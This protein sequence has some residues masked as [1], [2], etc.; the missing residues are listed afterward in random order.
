MESFPSALR[1]SPFATNYSLLALIFA[2]IIVSIAMPSCSKRGT[3]VITSKTSA[4]TPPENVTPENT[5]SF[6]QPDD[7]LGKAYSIR[8]ENL[9]SKLDPNGPWNRSH[10]I[11]K[12]LLTADGFKVLVIGVE[13]RNARDSFFN[14]RFDPKLTKPVEVKEG[15]LLKKDGHKTLFLGLTDL[16]DFVP[17]GVARTGGAEGINGTG[18]LATIRFETSDPL[19]RTSRLSRRYAPNDLIAYET[20]AGARLEW[21]HNLWGDTDNDFFCNSFDVSRIAQAYGTKKGDPN[22]NDSADT[23]RDGTVDSLDLMAIY[24]DFGIFFTIA[25]AYAG[26]GTLLSTIFPQIS[27]TGTEKPRLAID[28]GAPPVPTTATYYVTLNSPPNETPPSNIAPLQEWNSIN[29]EIENGRLFYLPGDEISLRITT[30]GDPGPVR[31]YKALVNFTA[32]VLS[33]SLGSSYLDTLGIFRP[34]FFF[35]NGFPGDGTLNL[36]TTALVKK[37][38]IVPTGKNTLVRNIRFLVDTTGAGD[39]QF[40]FTPAETY[41]EGP[42]NVGP[43]AF[44]KYGTLTVSLDAS[45]ILDVAIKASPT[46]GLL[47]FD[48]NFSSLVYGGTPPYSYFW[49]FDDGSFDSMA[50]PLH[51]YADGSITSFPHEYQVVLLVQDSASTQLQALDS[52]SVFAA[53]LKNRPPAIQSV[54]AMPGTVFLTQATSVD[55]VATDPDNDPLAY[56]WTSTLTGTF[57]NPTAQTTSYTPSELGTHTLIVTVS[58]GIFDD[59]GSTTVDVIQNMNPTAI[60]IAD[61]TS[62]VFPLTVNFDASQSFDTDGTIVLYEMDYEGDGTYDASGTNPTFQHTYP[63]W[64]TYYAMLRVTDD[65]GQ[66]S[67]YQLTILVTTP[68][69]G[70]FKRPEFETTQVYPQ[71]EPGE[72]VVGDFNEDNWDDIA[73][74]TTNYMFPMV[75]THQAQTTGAYTPNRMFSL[76]GPAT[77]IETR[78]LNGDN[79][80]D[81]I[82]LD[83][84]GS[85]ISILKGD[86]TGDFLTLTGITNLG[87]SWVWMNTGDYDGDTLIDIM[88]FSNPLAAGPGPQQLAVEMQFHKGNGDATFQAPLTITPQNLNY[89]NRFNSADLDGN[90]TLDV[91]FEDGGNIV[92][93]LNDGA[94][95]FTWSTPVRVGL[96]YTS[97]WRLGLVNSDQY[98]DLV[99]SSTDFVTNFQ[100]D[101]VTN[102]AAGGFGGA[103][104]TI[105]RNWYTYALAVGEFPAGS[106]GSILVMSD[107]SQLLEI[108]RYSGGT[109]TGPETVDLSHWG[110]YLLIGDLDRDL[111]PDVV[112]ADGSGGTIGI[113][114]SLPTD[115]LREAQFIQPNALSTSAVT[116]EFTGDTFPDL[117][118]FDTSIAP[119]IHIFGNDGTGKF[120]SETGSV[121][122]LAGSWTFLAGNLDN[123]NGD[124]FVNVGLTAFEI[125][126]YVNDGAGNFTRFQSGDITG[127]L[128]AGTTVTSVALSALA[129]WDTDGTLDLIL[130]GDGTF[131]PPRPPDVQITYYLFLQGQGDGTFRQLGGGITSPPTPLVFKVADFNKDTYPDA[132]ML[133]APGAAS[134]DLQVLAGDGTGLTGIGYQT[135]LDSLPIDLAVH[136]LNGDTNLD[137]IVLSQSGPFFKFYYGGAFFQFTEQPPIFQTDSFPRRVD[138]GDFNNDLTDDIIVL[139]SGLSRV[140]L[141]LGQGGAIF[142]KEVSFVANGYP[143]QMMVA[144]FDQ[145][146]KLDLVTAGSSPNESPLLTVLRNT[147]RN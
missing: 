44:A 14:I 41:F 107:S 65:F 47:P 138:V 1:R 83:N 48:V 76:P 113:S 38:P 73:L 137:L 26:D 20:Q 94:L 118:I 110:N 11:Y 53:G 34:E 63:S 134:Y 61:K 40:S 99:V 7:H 139:G 103:P 21:T 50:N 24:R 78:D 35:L 105:A 130:I 62:G 43:V 69:G 64:G 89:P 81:L 96:G 124:D 82:L 121:T 67:Q 70:P 55:V 90:G 146:A 77:H 87:S 95:N 52:V 136:D 100:L 79:H 111:N 9:D 112:T 2:L 101:V 27:A 66:T 30:N 46:S 58:D 32:G 54:T 22:Y 37:D 142:G 39:A 104:T 60:L 127:Y 25:N 135:L 119:G 45:K 84:Y 114:Y 59:V 115:Y 120:P 75:V 141:F 80:L 128:Q 133:F 72:P 140:E 86:G 116:G 129:D 13:L 29:F 17:V 36:L 6:R 109:Y 106:R 131:T 51:T 28:V 147:S 3:N 42:E 68:G 19:K 92:T 98:P 93:G 16:L 108:Y 15:N 10:T 126:S 85:H 132:A 56:S 88:T 33:Y 31:G 102:D 49:D 74:F 23:N 125:F 143:Y 5:N 97:S 145:D 71:Q 122:E 12:T 144:D 8:L 4:P 57:L 117:A 18:I 123:A 91:I